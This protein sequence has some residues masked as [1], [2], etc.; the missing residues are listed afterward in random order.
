MWP[1]LLSH[2][3]MVFE[4]DLLQ[5]DALMETFRSVFLKHVM[6]QFDENV[7]IPLSTGKPPA[8]FQNILLAA[9]FLFAGC[10]KF[11]PANCVSTNARPKP[12]LP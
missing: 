12:Y 6:D 3:I 1:S 8:S 2:R 4:H 11:R 10:R 9:N 7:I 5:V